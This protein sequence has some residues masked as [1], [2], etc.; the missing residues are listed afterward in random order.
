MDLNCPRCGCKLDTPR[1]SRADHIFLP[2]YCKICKLIFMFDKATSGVV[3]VD[4]ASDK[5]EPPVPRPNKIILPPLPMGTP[6]YVVNK[7]HP[8]F[9][10]QGVVSGVKHLHYRVKMVS[11]NKKLHGSFLWIVEHWVRELPQDM[12]SERPAEN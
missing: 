8:L 11:M 5:R 9:L 3:C 4:S 10:E 1:L 7:E 12:R 6:I 2:T